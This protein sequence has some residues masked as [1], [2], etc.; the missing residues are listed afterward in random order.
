MTVSLAST[1]PRRRELLAS[2][3]L[4][5][6]LIS[7]DYVEAHLPDRSPIETA[8]VHA[9]GKAEGAAPSPY[10]TIGSDTVVDL[11]GRTL[12]KPHSDDEARATLRALS[13]RS[14]EV[15]TA[16][17]LRDAA[18]TI[19]HIEAVTTRVRFA[20]LDDAVIDAYVAGGDPRDKAGSYGIQGFAATL[21]ERI[22]GDYFT[23]VGFPLSAFARALPRLGFRLLPQPAASRVLAGTP[24]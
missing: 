8:L 23:V 4:E 16:F 20:E 9:R 24:V 19:A 7:T 1:S 10:L 12:G 17:A 14:H 13:G 21:V 18:G 11:D 6:D 3:G 5:V 15:H 22:D 2:V